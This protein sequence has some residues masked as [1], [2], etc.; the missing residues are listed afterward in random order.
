MAF[1]STLSQKSVLNHVALLVP[2]VEKS[3]EYLRRQN[4]TIGPTER[5]DGEGTL[6]IYVSDSASPMGRLLLMEPIKEGAYTRAMEKRGPGL[7]HIAIDVLNV[8][9]FIDELSGSGWLLH[10]T[11][12]KTLKQTQTAWLSRP[13][14]PTLI[15]VQQREQLSE[16]TLLVSELFIPGLNTSNLPL[17]SRLGLNQVKMTD[18]A[19]LVLIMNGT[20][21]SFKNL[22]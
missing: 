20:V 17:F 4:F 8:E 7:H 1:N 6:E 21:I 18:K 16:A 5:W 15:E 2:S 13:G 22:C 19:E 11:S 14:I 12:I 10:P 3:A 9:H